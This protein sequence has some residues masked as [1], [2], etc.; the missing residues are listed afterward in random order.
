M[1][2]KYVTVHAPTGVA[3]VTQG[4]TPEQA[5]R[6]ALTQLNKY[7]GA[8]ALAGA[9]PASGGNTAVLSQQGAPV[10]SKLSASGPSPTA[11]PAVITLA[12]GHVLPPAFTAPAGTTVKK[13]K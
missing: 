10:G 8:P 4:Y 7:V 12:T 1:L 13:S 5:H 3:V 6:A 2:Q 11:L 9:G